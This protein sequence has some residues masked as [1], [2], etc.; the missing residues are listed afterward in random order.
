MMY[1]GPVIV[2]LEN[3]SVVNDS[4]AEDYEIIALDGK[5]GNGKKG[6]NGNGKGK[7]K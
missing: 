2:P 6:G 3:E 5:G 1:S 4:G 7:G